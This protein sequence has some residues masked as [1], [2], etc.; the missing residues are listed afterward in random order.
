MGCA[1]TIACWMFS[2]CGGGAAEPAGHDEAGGEATESV[3]ASTDP[4]DPQVGAPAS[5][6][7][8]A[9]LAH[10]R[11]CEGALSGEI[12]AGDRR[13]YEAEAASVRFSESSAEG[14]GMPAACASMDR[15]LATSCP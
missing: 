9:Y 6:E 12:A 13:S 15:E 8:A 1:L 2:G 14:P 7:C 11:R 5:P 4:T 10:Y 3:A